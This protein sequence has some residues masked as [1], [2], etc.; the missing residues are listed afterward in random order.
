MGVGA[1][2]GQRE[3]DEVKCIVFSNACKTRTEKSTSFHETRNYIC[4]A[5]LGQQSKLYKPI[6]HQLADATF[7][8]Q[9]S[10]SL[11]SSKVNAF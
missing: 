2:E 11:P 5:S 1:C 9:K 7:L 10:V 6:I 4:Q 3:G 8:Q